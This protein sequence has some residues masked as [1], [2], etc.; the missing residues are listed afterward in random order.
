VVRPAHRPAPAPR[1]SHLTARPRTRHP[2]LDQNLERQPPA[3][4]LDQDRRRNPRT[5]RLISSTNSWRGT[6]VLWLA[7]GMAQRAVGGLRPE[8]A[9][10]PGPRCRGSG[11]ALDLTAAQFGTQRAIPDLTW[12]SLGQRDDRLPRFDDMRGEFG[13]RRRRSAPRT[14]PAGRFRPSP[15]LHV[16][17]GWPSIWHSSDPSR[18]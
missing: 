8:A 14:G 17:A 7:A 1:R 2:R 15:A 10:T 18:R 3:L 4:H 12:R 5:P 13:C 11:A 6:L 16:L 9:A